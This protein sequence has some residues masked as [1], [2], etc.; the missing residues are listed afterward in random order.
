MLVGVSLVSAHPVS[1]QTTWVGGAARG[2][3]TTAQAN[4]ENAAQ[5]GTTVKI[6]PD[7][8]AR[9]AT[10]ITHVNIPVKTA[11]NRMCLVFAQ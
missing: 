2:L 8:G 4:T 10:P 7:R 11:E 3:R 9:W 5:P 1:Y 6:P